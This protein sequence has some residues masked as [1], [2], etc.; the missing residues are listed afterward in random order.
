MRSQSPP[1]PPPEFT[2]SPHRE[3]QTPL[4]DSI[5]EQ[6]KTSKAQRYRET[7]QPDP[8]SDFLD[9][10]DRATRISPTGE[11]EGQTC[12]KPASARIQPTWSGSHLLQ[13]LSGRQGIPFQPSGRHDHRVNPPSRRS[14]GAGSKSLQVR[15]V[16]SPPGRRAFLTL[17]W[18][19][20][21]TK[22]S[23]CRPCSL[24]EPEPSIPNGVPSWARRSTNASM[25][26][27][28]PFRHLRRP[29]LRESG[30]SCLER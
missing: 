15:P 18:H 27:G 16:R 2:Q 21:R 30:R 13:S 26:I 10:G 11:V 24:S 5:E 12:R 9:Y 1:G 17:P 8:S 7:S 4:P 23:A 3:L 6:S 19:V 28:Y 22:R 20:L 25:S 29:A 14:I